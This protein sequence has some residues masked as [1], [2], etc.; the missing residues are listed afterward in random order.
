MHPRIL[1]LHF[2]LLAFATTVAISRAHAN[3]TDLSGGSPSKLAFSYDRPF[4][5]RV[6]KEPS[7]DHEQNK[8]LNLG[9][10]RESALSTLSQAGPIKLE[11]SYNEAMS[12]EDALTYALRYNL[13]IRISKESYNYQKYRY[14]G[15]LAALAP[16]FSLSWN[17]TKSNI[18]P[19]DSTVSNARVYQAT[20]RYPVFQGG[21]N[22]YGALAQYYREKGWRNAYVASINDALLDVYKKY[23]NLVL[24]DCVLQIRANSLQVSEAQLNMNNAL[25]EAGTGTQFAIMQSRTQLALDRQALL[26]QQQETRNSAIQ[27]AY[28]LNLPL[29][30][31]LVPFERDVGEKALWDV[32]NLKINDLI[33]MALVHR[34]EL[35][36]YELFRLA[37]ARNVQVAAAPLYPAVSF[38]TSFA[39]ASTTVNPTNGSAASSSSSSSSSTSSSSSSSSSTDTATA[40]V[41]SGLTNTK[42]A[43]F[44]LSWSVPNM[45]LGTLANIVSARAL[46]RQAMSQANQEL[47]KVNQQVRTALISAVTSRALIDAAAYSAS[48]AGDALRLANMRVRTGLGTNLELIQA[49]RDYINALVNQAKAITQSNQAQAQ[50]LHDTGLISV[51]TLLNG[52]K[53]LAPSR[54][55][56]RRRP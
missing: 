34:P 17:L 4:R 36:Q 1:L 24:N 51:S 28:A 14:Y 10:L 25:Y 46:S 2:S 30:V 45:A 22:V 29:G 27:L 12:L 18:L 11:A 32:K 37:A 55:D 49:Q 26:Q 21:S 20:V 54:T 40:G 5:L 48:S 6:P 42:Q 13:P 9:P 19:P 39:H 7:A 31:N 41:F 23:T 16:N 47:L 15:T 8:I 43:G 56:K 53:D 52:Y 44:I 35:R 50:L 38:F 33:D 3:D